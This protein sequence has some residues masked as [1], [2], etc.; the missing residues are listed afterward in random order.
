MAR[1]EVERGRLALSFALVAVDRLGRR[2]ET[3]R[4]RFLF[5]NVFGHIESDSGACR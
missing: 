4:E 1:N 2:I 3:C 5:Q